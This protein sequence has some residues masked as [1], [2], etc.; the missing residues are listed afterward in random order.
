MKRP[1]SE[2]NDIIGDMTFIRTVEAV[3]HFVC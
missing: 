2:V 1:V 3:I